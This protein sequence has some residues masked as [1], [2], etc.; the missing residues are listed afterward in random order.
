MDLGVVD[1]V[2]CLLDQRVDGGNEGDGGDYTIGLCGN[3]PPNQHLTV[4]V[5]LFKGSV[6]C[7]LLIKSADLGDG[8][9]DHLRDGL[10][11]CHEGCRYERG[12]WEAVAEYLLGGV[13]SGGECRNGCGVGEGSHVG[14]GGYGVAGTRAEA[15]FFVGLGGVGARASSYEDK[16]LFVWVRSRS[17]QFSKMVEE[18]NVVGDGCFGY[19]D[20]IDFFGRGRDAGIDGFLMVETQKRA[21]VD[22]LLASFEWFAEKWFSQVFARIV[23]MIELIVVVKIVQNKYDLPSQWRI[24]F[25]YFFQLKTR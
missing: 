12:E 3:Q 18:H 21:D 2:A 23:G 7:V 19:E 16:V 5:C 11:G 25:F 9:D 24:L 8:G 20:G 6:F 13:C 14:P 15:G 1:M 22:L 10:I 4:F 17:S